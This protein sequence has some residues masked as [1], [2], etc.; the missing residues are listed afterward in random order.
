L[1]Q[2]V[3]ARKVDPGNLAL[4]REIDVPGGNLYPDNNL[5]SDCPA[6]DATSHIVVLTAAVQNCDTAVYSKDPSHYTITRSALNG[7]VDV[8]DNDSVAAGGPFPP[9]DGEHDTL[10]NIEN[11][12]FCMGNDPVSKA[13]NS[14]FD[15][16][17]ADATQPPAAATLSTATLAFPNRAVPAGPGDPLSFT[18]T[19]TGAGTL[20]ISGSTIA[21]GA[22]SFTSTNTCVTPV[23]P[24]THNVSCTFTVLFDPTAAG[25]QTA[26]LTVNTSVGAKTVALTGTGVN[27]TLATGA[28]TVSDTTPTEGRAITVSPL[29]VV[30]PDGIPASFT[31]QWSRNNSPTGTVFTPI[32]GA[33]GFTYTPVSADVNRRL[34]A[35]VSF[36]D[37]AG[38][39][40]AST[41]LPTIVVGNLFP[42][43]GETNAGADTTLTAVGTAGQDEFHGG[44]GNDA[45]TTLAE[46]DLISGDAGDDTIVSGAG[47]DT[48]TF[49]GTG[50]GFDNVTGGAGTDSILAL[51]N[52]TNIGLTTQISGVEVISANGHTGVHILGSAVADALNFSATVLQ[53][54]IDIDG[55]DGGDTIS[56]SA[57]NDT[58][59]GRAGGDTLNGNGGND[60]LDGGAGADT[61]AG[62]AGIDAL[63]GGAGDDTLNGGAGDDTLT[64]GA[65]NDSLQGGGGL[66]VFRYLA[67]FGADTIQATFDANPTGGQD[68]IDLSALGVTSANFSTRVTIQANFTVGLTTNNTLITVKD[69]ANVVLGTITLIGVSG[70][71]TAANTITVADFTLA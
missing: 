7:S 46:D 64:G 34:T 24:L 12:R 53:N 17:S 45:L 8:S 27:N 41:S 57:T 52:G 61:L 43:P 58:I 70:T 18:V 44:A 50:D 51:T 4:V 40:E 67:A 16:R 31:Y 10:W 47:N 13:C 25:V 29:G 30:D 19:N 37:N 26:T 49:A 65:G 42:G 23:V 66:N 36:V 1:Q 6:N 20:T 48:I 71:G 59:F 60:S 63:D 33:T 39:N 2:A 11:L 5:S 22:G 3:F 56:G 38:S 21:G 14:F 68:K 69:A 32:T 28:P 62:G 35:T 54:I 55:G 15:I 9:G